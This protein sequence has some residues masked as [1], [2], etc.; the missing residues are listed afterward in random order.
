MKNYILIIFIFLLSGNIIIFSEQSHIIDSHIIEN[1]IRALVLSESGNSDE[2]KYHI[3]E[4]LNKRDDLFRPYL[5]LIKAH[6]NNSL[7]IER[8][9]AYIEK[10]PDNY[11]ALETYARLLLNNDKVKEAMD[12]YKDLIIYTG[13]IKYHAQLGRLLYF[14]GDRSE[15]RKY[16]LY[17]AENSKTINPQDELIFYLL[18][19]ILE[20][21]QEYAL[22]CYYYM[23]S[24]KIH[25]YYRYSLDA[26]ESL[27]SDKKLWIDIPSFYSEMMEKG[28]NEEYFIN[29]FIS[30]ILD[31][32]LKDYYDEIVKLIKERHDI[33][34]SNDIFFKRSLIYAYY[35]SGE[36]DTAISML[37]NREDLLQ[38]D[39]EMREV[40]FNSLLS[41]G[42]HQG[43][44]EFL[45]SYENEIHPVNYGLLLYR[46]L[47][48]KGDYKEAINRIRKVYRS[49]SSSI[50]IFAEFIRAV[51]TYDDKEKAFSLL[52]DKINE[53]G[54]DD[55][56]I[57]YI[58]L[59]LKDNRIDTV[60]YEVGELYNRSY[61]SRETYHFLFSIS[62]LYDDISISEEFLGRYILYH[63]DIN[64]YLIMSDYF[65]KNEN[66][67]SS[68][69]ILKEAK[70][71]FPDSRDILFAFSGYY[72][73]KDNLSQSIKIL[74]K[75]YERYPYIPNLCNS[76]AY[77][78]ILKGQNL[79]KAFELL[80]YVLKIEPVN[81]AYLDS[82]GW[83]YYTIEDYDTALYYLKHALDNM[84]NDPEI[85]EHL[86]MVYKKT[87]DYSYAVKYLK[88]SLEYYDRSIDKN[89]IKNKIESLQ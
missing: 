89:R 67:Y 37:K 19:N 45:K 66:Y 62:L 1:Y 59:L 24:I 65:I 42:D 60:N 73:K 2:I 76:L 63:N 53:P 39:S 41:L 23:K 17:Y 80:N 36:Y 16:L 50:D 74:E 77:I 8:I 34:Q 72:Y 78:Y 86:G 70:E 30:H 82:M 15:A 32:K 14:Y 25:P 7:S 12:V 27:V 26:F 52:Y 47:L 10:Y 44:K 83:Y 18:G 40:F 3:E 79:D 88:L 49:H 38:S 9:E 35:L 55:L 51:F 33:E 68:Y 85:Y 31:N 54:H 43:A 46:V 58:Q 61:I 5:Y 57:F 6:G 4:I 84:E 75:I 87:G 22:A 81:P 71:K 13:D 56:W 48:S 11:T 20:N 21:E 64:D 69:R 29:R 28:Q